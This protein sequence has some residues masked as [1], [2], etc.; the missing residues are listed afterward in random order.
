M[1]HINDEGSLVDRRIQFKID[2]GR[3]GTRSASKFCN[4]HMDFTAQPCPTCLVAKNKID[5]YNPIEVK[6][7]EMHLITFHGLVR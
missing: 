7:F 4:S 1:L 5:R 2:S 3:Q 6:S